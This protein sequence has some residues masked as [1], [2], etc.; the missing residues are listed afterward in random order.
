MNKHYGF[1]LFRV[2]LVIQ[3]Q[4][5]I[6]IC[7]VHKCIQDPIAIN[8]ILLYGLSIIV[9]YYPLFWYEISSGA[10]NQYYSLIEYYLSIFDQVI[11]EKMLERITGKSLRIYE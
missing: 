2:N 4:I 8:F 6:F 3:F 10:L 9:R 7:P 5:L 1:R 11:L